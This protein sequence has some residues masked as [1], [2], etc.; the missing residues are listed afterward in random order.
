MN[1]T[2]TETK[3]SRPRKTLTV[4]EV[5]QS[6]EVAALPAPTGEAIR[7]NTTVEQCAKIR[8]LLKAV[9]IK[10]VSVKRSSSS[11]TAT[12]SVSFASIP[13][14]ELQNWATHASHECDI[15]IRNNK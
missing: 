6:I 7:A 15:C 4:F 3:T 14:L 11:W 8:S 12:V 2:T 10:G 13:H 5:I 1:T 9:G